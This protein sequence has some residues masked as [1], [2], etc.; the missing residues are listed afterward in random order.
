MPRWTRATG[1]ILTCLAIAFSVHGATVGV[2]VREAL[3]RQSTAFVVVELGDDG[4][5]ADPVA[6]RPNRIGSLQDV[7]LSSLSAADF[8]VAARWASLPGLAG[9]VTAAG[10]ASLAANPLVRRI[11]L[12][13]AGGGALAESSPL[14]G[15]PSVHAQGYTGDG[16]VVAVLDSG[17][18]TSHPDLAGA[19]I[20]EHC[21][22]RN[23]LGGGC[24]P[25]GSGEQS[26]LGS[27]RDDHGHGTN[28][29]G[30]I[31]S[32]GT[33]S[34]KGIAPGTSI[35]AVR[36]LD[37]QNRFSSTTQIISALDWLI[38]TRPEVKVVNMSLGTDARFEGN[39]DSVTSWTSLFAT[40]I[41]TL[42]AR[43]TA[44]FVSAGNDGAL[45]T[46][47]APACIASALAVGAVYDS[48][49]GALSFSNCSDATTDADR[50]ACFS[51]SSSAL[52]LL[53]PGSRVTSTGLLTNT[54]TYNGTSQASPH[55]AGGA[56]LIAQKRAGVTVDEIESV[57]ESTGRPVTDHRTGSVFPRID[58]GAAMAALSSVGCSNSETVAC[59]DN[60][61]TVSVDYSTSQSGGLSGKGRA[62]STEPIGFARGG[63]FWFFDPSNPEMLVKVLN[64]CGLNQRY[65]FFA[66]AGTNVGYTITV[67]DTARGVSK[68]Y[69][70]TDL[71]PAQPIQDTGAFATCP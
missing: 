31:A 13:V 19:V 57:L 10:L 27:A 62:A 44:T 4:M 32:R 49:M 1:S 8:R 38:T 68:T 48:A 61:F 53:A 23:T 14:V 35:V 28:V 24:C 55:A 56:A 40:A 3:Q 25:N 50:V 18:R 47:Q 65:W 70:N 42:R 16:V 63:L 6:R 58:L 43:G 26:G 37:A 11:D 71:S 69:I 67:T 41:G 33:V 45:S 15:A 51:N 12:D 30:I 7:V 64:G 2:E 54:V 39:C 17:V 36:V 22:C 60:R 46:M 52:D 21:F 5:P 20:A 34:P 9:E 29:T 59:I 66:S